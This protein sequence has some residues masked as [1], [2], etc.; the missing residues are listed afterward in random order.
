M[1][2]I[3][4]KTF[5]LGLKKKEAEIR[6]YFDKHFLSEKLSY[7]FTEGVG[8]HHNDGQVTSSL[9]DILCHNTIDKVSIDIFKNHL[10]M[11]QTA[12]DDTSVQHAL[13][14]EDDARFPSWNSS[15]WERIQAWLHEHSR[16]WDIFYLGYCNWPYPWSTFATKD[17]VQ[18]ASPLTAHAYILNRQGMAKIL[19]IVEQNPHYRNTLHID[20]LFTM[21]P[22]FQK[23]G[24]YPMASFQEKCPGLYLKACDKLK[25]RILFKTCCKWNEQFSVVF[26]FVIIFVSVFFISKFLGKIKIF[27][28]NK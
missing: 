2:D 13:F 5:V 11:I 9:W 10:Q 16:R 25:V 14:L 22:S 17:I 21:I 12:Y 15:K 19:S 23:Y 1:I 18:I 3:V 27:D 8:A 26:P 7:H 6:N 24:M 4:D 20:K 28:I